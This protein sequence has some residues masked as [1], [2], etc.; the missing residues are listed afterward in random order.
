MVHACNGY[1]IRKEGNKVATVLANVYQYLN[2]YW[3]DTFL[4]CGGGTTTVLTQDSWLISR[5]MDISSQLQLSQ[6]APWDITKMAWNG[7]KLFLPKSY[8]ASMENSS[9]ELRFIVQ[10]RK[11]PDH[12]RRNPIESYSLLMKMRRHCTH[13]HLLPLNSRVISRGTLQLVHCAV[14]SGLPATLR[15]VAINLLPYA[16]LHL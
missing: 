3:I 9:T 6:K 12:A 14:R 16:C 13:Q 8:F 1:R 4:C 11:G 10:E 2:I 7:P 15:K 5:A